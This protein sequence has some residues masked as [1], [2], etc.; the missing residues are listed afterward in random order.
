MT[1]IGGQFSEQISLLLRHG[2]LPAA[3]ESVLKTVLAEGKMLR[4]AELVKIAVG[5]QVKAHMRRFEKPLQI[6][7]ETRHRKPVKLAGR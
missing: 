1:A 6:H 5:G 7:Q 2:L 3:G 4:I